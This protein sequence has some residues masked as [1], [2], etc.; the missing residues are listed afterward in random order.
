MN[1]NY[2]YF[3]IETAPLPMEK[4]AHLEPKFKAPSNYKTEEAIAKAISAKREEWY[5]QAALSPITGEIVYIGLLKDK[6]FNSKGILETDN[7][8][9]A[10]ILDF[11][12]KLQA[13]TILV[14]WNIRNFDIPYIIQRSW[15]YKLKLPEILSQY[16]SNSYTC[17]YVLDL[18]QYF[19]CN[20]KAYIS[21][22]NAAKFL[23]LGS[24]GGESGD[25]FAPKYF[26]SKEL[27]ASAISYN[28]NELELLKLIHERLI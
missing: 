20:T 7:D 15:K 24:K 19:S 23:D 25:L 6:E 10:L 9:K 3:D 21:L 22:D 4:I 14:G 27:R 11:F 12:S 2:L 16:M 13:D 1:N 8:E 5:D 18:M 28:N 26:A 17:P